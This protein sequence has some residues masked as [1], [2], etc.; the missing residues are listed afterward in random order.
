MRAINSGSSEVV[1]GSSTETYAEVGLV[2]AAQK[3][4]SGETTILEIYRAKGIGMPIN[5][6]EKEFSTAEITMK[7]RRDN[8]RNGVFKY[9]RNSATS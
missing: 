2:I 7:L 9:H 4:G 5:L 3:R 8:A 6:T 1:I